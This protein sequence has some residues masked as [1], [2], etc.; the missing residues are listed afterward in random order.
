MDSDIAVIGK[1]ISHYRIVSQLG[2]G[3]MGVVY[4]AE[5]L[6]LHRHVALKF[7]PPEMEKDPAARER[8]QREA[9]ATSALN[10]PNICTIYEI[11]EA[12]GRYFIAMELLRGQTLKH[13]I[14]GKPIGIGHVLELAAEVVD[15]LDAAHSKGIVHR[16]I[17]PANILIADRGHSKILDFGLAKVEQRPRTAEGVTLSQLPTEGASEQDLTSPGTMLGTVAYMSPEQALGEAID[18]R[19]DL[20][21]FGVVLY[22][23]AT[24]RL[25]F[26]GNTSAAIFN[27]ILNKAP[28]PATHLNPEV[29]PELDMII[30]KAL[31]KDRKLRYQSAAEIRSDLDRLKRDTESARSPAGD[32]KDS[33]VR[34]R[35]GNRWKVL[36]PAAVAVLAA[37]A[38]GGYFYSR[39]IPTLTD[40]DTIVLAD[41]A[42]ST[43]D[44]IFDGTLK[45]ALATDLAQ[46]PFINILSDNRV[47]DTLHLMGRS[48]SERLTKEVSREIC[49]RSGSKALIAGSI[50]GLGNNYVIGLNAENCEIGDSLGREQG[51]ATSR[52]NVLHV[53]GDTATQLRK[54]LGESIASIQKD[55]RPLDQVTTSSLEALKAESESVRADLEKGDQ[56]ALPFLER[57]VEL[58]PNFASAYAGLGIHYVNLGQASLAIQNFKRAFELRDRVS[59]RERLVISGDYYSVVTGELQKSNQ[60][61]QLAIEEYPRDS[62]THEVLAYNYAALGD[63]SKAEAETREALR[64]EPN[65]FTYQAESGI[66]LALDRLGEAQI[67]IDEALAHWFDNPYLHTQVY[68]LAFLRGDATEMQHQLAWATGTPGVEDIFLAAQSDTET[69]YGR[70]RG[71]RDFSQKA[72][73]SARRHGAKETA[74]QWQVD[75]ALHEVEVGNI[76]EARQTASTA[77]ALSSGRD[78]E[79]QA[80]LAFA[81]AG[82]AIQAQ[83]LADKLNSEF[84]LSTLVQGYWLPTIRAAME[85]TRG[86][87]IKA[88]APLEAARPYDLSEVISY[89]W[90]FP[91]YIRGQAYLRTGNGSEAATEFQRILDHRGVILNYPLGSLAH[92]G[93][94]RAYAA[95]GNAT[96]AR[97]DYQDFF[98]LWKNADPS[99]P[100]LQQA[101]AEYAKLK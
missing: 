35:A 45:Q 47:A 63:L 5:D 16:D 6:K 18:V 15:A 53:L 20:F 69:Y 74:A 9:F 73:E 88:L 22:E 51:E 30:S 21:S 68:M 54:K 31:E 11:D 40:K 24:G 33:G 101:K 17:K 65:A 25:P 28:M 46:S 49:L 61:F 62:E 27:A 55:G 43:N 3:G 52:E 86:D 72:V 66:Y 82:D 23:M 78:V 50:A 91:V 93:L 64:L 13:R 70:L 10:H 81:W 96:K 32:R 42:N 92:L 77:L 36:V 26:P 34:G 8:F 59:D 75:A 83:K 58:D 2:G 80:A 37:L 60:Q 4:E 89:G 90:M 100:I 76:A 99:I 38:V 12:N 44:P 95:Q 56:A 98:A 94:G 39:R 7:L 19:T 14:S 57:A 85:L 1:T 84:P 41:F 87:A 48:P 71:A 97:A 29:P 79:S 67:T